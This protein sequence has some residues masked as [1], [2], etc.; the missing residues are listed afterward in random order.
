MMMVMMMMSILA[1]PCRRARRLAYVCRAISLPRLPDDLS[2]TI[3]LPPLLLRRP[4]EEL[5]R[6]VV[7]KGAQVPKR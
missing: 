1:H 7:A 5:V 3:D 6:V 4:G 2:V